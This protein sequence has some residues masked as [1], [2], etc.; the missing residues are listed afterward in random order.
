M[1]KRFVSEALFG[2]G[3]A[4]GSEMTSVHDPCCVVSR[5]PPHERASQVDEWVKG[6]GGS[7]AV[8]VKATRLLSASALNPLNAGD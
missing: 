5:T 2:G 3:G 6:H 4:A 1:D 8:P 7:E